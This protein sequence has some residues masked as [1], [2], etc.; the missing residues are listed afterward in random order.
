MGMRWEMGCCG[1][2]FSFFPLRYHGRSSRA[3]M[4]VCRAFG[5]MG[6]RGRS[7][8]WYYCILA[9]MVLIEQIYHGCIRRWRMASLVYINRRLLFIIEFARK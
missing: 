7:Y 8:Y 4:W 3:D 2:F 5:H 9:A 1:S 6:K